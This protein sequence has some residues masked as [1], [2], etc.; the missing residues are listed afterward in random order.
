[1]KYQNES[2]EMRKGSSQQSG[3]R[4]KKLNPKHLLDLKEEHPFKKALKAL[5]TD[6][7][8]KMD[9]YLQKN[10]DAFL[11]TTSNSD[12]TNKRM[13][14]TAKD[15]STHSPTNSAGN[16]K[17]TATSTKDGNAEG[18]AKGSSVSQPR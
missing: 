3:A 4:L 6:I 17:A 7:T 13:D 9:K 12:A 18:T 16:Q 14:R 10:I 5:R 11:D 15:P 1:M 8:T 2:F